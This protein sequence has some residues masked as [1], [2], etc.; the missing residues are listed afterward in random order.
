MQRDPQPETAGMFCLR[1][2]MNQE[3]EELRRQKKEIERRIAEIKNAQ[4]I[5]G[6]AK[7]GV[8]HYSTG[9]EDRWYVAVQRVSDTFTPTLRYGAIING[10]SMQEVRD[11]I[12]AIVKD[13]QNLYEQTK[14]L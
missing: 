5:S 12:P 3:L 13:L 1:R 9:K 7:I 2:R 10:K 6:K 8:E 4:Y 14:D 11:C